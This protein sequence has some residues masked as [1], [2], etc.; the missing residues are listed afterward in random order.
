[1]YKAKTK[2]IAGLLIFIMMFT[3]ISIVGEV[4]ALSLEDQTTKTNHSNV[5]FGAYFLEGKNKTHSTEQTIGGENYLYA[6]I[7]VKQAGYLKNASILLENTN[8]TIVEAMQSEAISKVEKNKITLN[9]IKNGNT[10]ELA[11]PIQMLEESNINV[12]EFSKENTVTFEGT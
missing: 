2:L 11:I 10:V 6:T 9:Q 1:M 3:Y 4:L 5:E 7:S 8:F 12:A